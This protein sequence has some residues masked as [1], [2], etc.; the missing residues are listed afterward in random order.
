MLGAR[1]GMEGWLTEE[2]C[3]EVLAKVFPQLSWRLRLIGPE[4]RE[5]LRRMEDTIQ[6]E[7]A[8]LQGHEWML[9]EDVRAPDLVVCFN[10]GI[11]TLSLSITK[12]WLLTVAAVLKLDVPVL[13]TSFGIKEQKGEDF[14]LRGLFKAHVLVDFQENPF[15][16]RPE[17]RPG[18]YG[19]LEESLSGDNGDLCN[20]HIWWAAGSELPEEE[21]N[22]VALKAPKLLEELTQN[23]ALQG[24]HRSW[25][26]AL[27]EGN[28]RVGEAAM[29]NFQVALQNPAV[30]RVLAKFAKHI[31]DAMVIFVRRYGP[32]PMAR[33]CVEEVLLS[34]VRNTLPAGLNEEDLREAVR[35]RLREDYADERTLME[36]IES[37]EL[38]PEDLMEEEEA[39]EEEM[40]E[41]ANLEQS[42]ASDAWANGEGPDGMGCTAVVA[43]LRGGGQPEVL[44]TPPPMDSNG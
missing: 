28:Q 36:L 23:Y 40:E 21:L 5:D 2:G 8:R 32:H 12:P 34:K 18:C 44:V 16:Q 11:G 4:M 1:S 43:L 38:D 26:V 39:E 6:V 29:V 22:E 14:L 17:D 30:L 3:W 41:D 37:G 35:E 19:S 42:S 15:R 9:R 25:I 27:K 13:F 24:A 10:S 7:S 33:K 31:A 20:S